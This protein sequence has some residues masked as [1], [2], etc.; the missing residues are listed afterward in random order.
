[1]SK[2]SVHRRS[3]LATSAVGGSALALPAR[4]YS[5]L[6]GANEKLNIAFLGTGGRCQQHIDVIVDMRDEGKP[7]SPCAVCD[8]WDG[9]EKLGKRRDDKKNRSGRGLYPSAKTCGIALDAGKNRI[10]KD[11][12]A[13]LDNKDV[14]V[15]CIATP[16]H[17]HARMALDA[18]DAGKH[19][20]MEKP[21]T[22]TIAEA[23]AV[24]DAA[25]KKNKVVTV[26][27]QSMADQIGRASCRERV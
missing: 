13:I 19:V 12:R 8:V 1:M 9:D 14:D 18:I 2:K 16:D 22:R 17:W 26:G 27:V 25:A 15:V 20:Y 23:I 3:F 21:M 11:Y 4:S 24:V 7:V 6:A 5:A 10:N